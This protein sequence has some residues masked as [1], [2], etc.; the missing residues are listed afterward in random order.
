MREVRLAAITRSMHPACAG[1]RDLAAAAAARG[2]LTVDADGW[3]PG[4]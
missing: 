3:P 4:P 2:G 1:L